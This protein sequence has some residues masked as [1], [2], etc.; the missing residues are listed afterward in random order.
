MDT[1]YGLILDGL[2][3]VG[4][5]AFCTEE[6]KH[7]QR[8]ILKMDINSNYV[9]ISNG[10]TKELKYILV[11]DISKNDENKINTISN[12]LYCKIVEDLGTGTIQGKFMVDVGTVHYNNA[13]FTKSKPKINRNLN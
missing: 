8:Q 9:D 5:F 11:E 10:S 1:K 2:I 3:A 12:P 4:K 6:D 13:I 7:G